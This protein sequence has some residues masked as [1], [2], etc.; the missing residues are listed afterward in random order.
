MAP[1]QGRCRRKPLE[2]RAAPGNG[3]HPLGGLWRPGGARLMAAECVAGAQ[4]RE[5]GCS[6]LADEFWEIRVKPWS[7]DRQTDRRLT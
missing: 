3:V 1:L 7:T 4:A 6:G 2:R 5:R